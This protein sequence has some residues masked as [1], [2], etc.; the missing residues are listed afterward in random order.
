MG[1]KFVERSS[2][3]PAKIPI[4]PNGQLADVTNPTHR[5]PFSEAARLDGVGFVLGEEAIGLHYAGIDLDNCLDPLTGQIDPWAEEVIAFSN[6]YAE[7]SPSGRGVK[8]FAFGRFPEGSRKRY[9]HDGGSI[10]LYDCGRF[11]T[12]TGNRLVD[13]PLHVHDRGS[14]LRILHRRFEEDRLRREAA[15]RS[16]PFGTA[17]RLEPQ[18]NGMDDAAVIQAAANA[19]NGAKFN[20]LWSGDST[21]YP[22]PSEADLALASILTF[23]V[24]PDTA[25]IADLMRQS[26]MSS[27]R[28]KFNRPDYLPRTIKRAIAS[29]PFFYSPPAR[30]TTPGI[31]PLPIA[32][33]L[34]N[35][36]P[37]PPEVERFQNP[38]VRKLAA[39]CFHLQTLKGNAIPFGLDQRTAGKLLGVSAMSANKYFRILTEAGLLEVISIGKNANR[40]ASQYRF[41]SF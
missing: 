33:K 38:N 28:T 1:W 7:I 25:R 17:T 19:K 4:R 8:I 26:G 27:C 37:T 35:E 5:G 34:A 21:G 41:R 3:K 14:E 16:T 15:L 40:H 31:N 30:S 24:G 29:C 20:R 18:P 22:S 10:E 39:L 32:W 12:V 13:S 9:G 6:S 2:G 23:W 36:Q 11:F